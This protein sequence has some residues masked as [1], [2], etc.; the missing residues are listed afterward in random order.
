MS[1]GFFQLAHQKSLKMITS[2]NQS[3]AIIFICTISFFLGTTGYTQT[4]KIYSPEVEERIASV[5]NNL[6][7][8]V[9][10]DS[11]RNWN[12]YQRMKD[13]KVKGIS[14]AVIDSYKIDWV[15]SYGWA[16]TLEGKAV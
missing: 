5:E 10:L 4:A 3:L 7:S 1:N 15:K 12:I 13:L 11:V 14:I 8:W 9:R 16:D 2:I 6:V